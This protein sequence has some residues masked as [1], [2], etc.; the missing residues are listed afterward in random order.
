MHRPAN[1]GKS[2]NKGHKRGPT[3]ERHVDETRKRVKRQAR[4][5]TTQHTTHNN[6]NPLRVH[7]HKPSKFFHPTHPT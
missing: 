6:T 2:R 3:G 7:T 1:L 4:H 5:D